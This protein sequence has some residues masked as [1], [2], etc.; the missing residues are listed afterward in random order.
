MDPAHFGMWLELQASSYYEEVIGQ[1]QLGTVDPPL[2]LLARPSSCQ[3]K[4][5]ETKHWSEKHF[6]MRR[7]RF[8]S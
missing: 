6:L 2:E 7:L 8:E 3:D 5:P 4:Q 1:K